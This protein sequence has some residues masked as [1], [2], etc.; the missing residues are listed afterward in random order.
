MDPCGVLFVYTRGPGQCALGQ[1][2]DRD[3]SANDGVRILAALGDGPDQ[4]LAARSRCLDRVVMV[5]GQHTRLEWTDHLG[6][7]ADRTDILG[8]HG[9]HAG[10]SSL[11]RIRVRPTIFAMD[12][13]A[14]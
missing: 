5:P 13:D 10:R 8:G 9:T 1:R 4:S 6:P 14:F 7:F 2:T 3:Q 11:A 12:R